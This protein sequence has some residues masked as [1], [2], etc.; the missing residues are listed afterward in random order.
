MTPG[1]YNKFEII[2]GATWS[3]PMTWKLPVLDIS[4]VSSGINPTITTTAAHGL[5]AGQTVE[6]AG[7]LG[8]TGVNG[9][10]TVL[11]TPTT[12]TFTVTDSAPG[13]YTSGGT[14]TPI[15]NLTGYTARMQ[16]RDSANGATVLT[17]LTTA[18]GKITL[19]GVAGT[20][21]LALSATETAALTW[22]WGQYNLE[23][24]TGSHVDR[25]LEGRVT[26]RSEVT[27]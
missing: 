21:T 6:I 8:A 3:Q 26:V 2:Q 14:V 23:L 27:R 5:A 7:V 12:T 19:G 20:I 18:N 15:V 22:T 4:G 24:A 10:Q 1:E 17:E 16:I 13:T 25:L 9:A 11:A